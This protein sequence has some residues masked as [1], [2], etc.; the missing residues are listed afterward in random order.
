MVIQEIPDNCLKCG[1]SKYHKRKGVVYY[2]CGSRAGSYEM[3]TPYWF[4][5]SNSCELS[6]V[7]AFLGEAVKQLYH[8]ANAVRIL[9][10]MR[11]DAF[12]L[13]RNIEQKTE[14]GS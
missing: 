12:D 13:I 3:S 9:S 10:R 4:V 7:K 5:Q 1:A 11:T 14:S 6:I 2:K 8:F